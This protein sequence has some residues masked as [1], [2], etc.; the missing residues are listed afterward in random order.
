[1]ADETYD[2]D[3]AVSATTLRDAIK[4]LNYFRAHFQRVTKRIEYSPED[5]R[6]EHF[7]KFVMENY[8]GAIPLREIYRK[9]LFHCNGREEAETL[10]KL[11]C[12]RGFGI[13]EKNMPNNGPGRP[14][15]VFLVQSA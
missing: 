13:L 10:C 12:D 7:V 11:A 8:N 3:Q 14:G 15:L 1:V 5:R 2:L 4:V 9:R 6:I